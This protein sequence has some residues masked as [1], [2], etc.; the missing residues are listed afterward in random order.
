MVRAIL[1]GRKTQTRRI[2]KAGPCR[3]GRPGDRLWVRETFCIE[4]TRDYHGDHHVPIDG[5]PVK[6]FNDVDF[7]SYWLIPHYRATEPEPH[8]VPYRCD[9]DDDRTRWQPSIH[10]PRWASRLALTIAD[11]RAER[12]QDISGI[13]AMRE[14]VS[15]PAYPPQDGTDLDHARREFRR[16]WAAIH[17][18]EALDS[19]PLVWVI[20]FGV[21]P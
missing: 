14:G 6:K 2:A 19:N 3:Y 12:P 9:A 8:I 7:G 4:N 13:D 20:S 17:G 15:I 5:R 16:L 18:R 1:D 21:A 10:M 11:V